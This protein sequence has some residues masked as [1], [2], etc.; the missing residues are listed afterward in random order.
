M[1]QWLTRCLNM[2][3]VG[4]DQFAL[5]VEAHERQMGVHTRCCA[6]G[7]GTAHATAVVAAATIRHMLDTRYLGGAYQLERLLDIGHMLEA[8]TEKN[9]QVSEHPAT[10]GSILHQAAQPFSSYEQT[11][12]R[13]QS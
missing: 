13:L 5:V 12:E 1:L 6:T 2:L 4:A 7:F 8:L 10:V 11:G 3:S 9:I